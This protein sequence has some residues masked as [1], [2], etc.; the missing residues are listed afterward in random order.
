MSIK[1]FTTE[2]KLLPKTHAFCLSRVVSIVW[3][4]ITNLSGIRLAKPQGKLTGW[5]RYLT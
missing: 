5:G 2:L 4:E 3:L 1:Y